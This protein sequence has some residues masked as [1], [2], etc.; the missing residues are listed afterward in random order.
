MRR[1]LALVSGGAAGIGAATVRALA[2]DGCDVVILDLARQEECAREVI[3]SLQTGKGT[4]SFLE[5]DAMDACAVEAAVERACAMAGRSAPDIVVGVVGGNPHK[6]PRGTIY[7]ESAS[8][9]RSTVE[10]TLWTAH[11]LLR[12]CS[13]KMIASPDRRSRCFAFITSVMIHASRSGAGAYTMAKSALRQLARTSAAS[14]GKFMIRVNTI[15]PGWIDTPQER[16]SASREEMDRYA[17]KWPLGRMGRAA[18]VGDA[19]AFLCSPRASY[20]TGAELLVDGGFR[21]AFDIPSAAK[22]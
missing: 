12:V 20:I 16:L 19:V 4:V 22:L 7:E 2:R 11:S 9:A 15:E 14:L 18:D 5:S 21:A 10:M 3:A 8:E 1:P 13:R 17:A 6:F